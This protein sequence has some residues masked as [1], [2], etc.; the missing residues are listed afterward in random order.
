[1]L[2]FFLRL[3]LSFLGVNFDHTISFFKHV[4]LL[5]DQ[6]FSRLKVSRSVSDSLRGPSK[7]SY[8]LFHKAFLHPVL[9]DASPGCF[10]F[11]ELPSLP[12]WNESSV[13]SSV[14]TSCSFLSLFFYQKLLCL[15][16]K[17]PW[18]I[19]LYDLTREPVFF[20]PLALLQDWLYTK[21]N[22]GFPSSPE[23]TVLPMNF[24]L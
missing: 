7:E 15:S 24:L 14:A 8:F 11:S 21:K 18:F 12:S 5:K 16:N 9:P 23:E 1:M 17:L 13:A 3:N 10:F 19:S 2:N 20:H 22:Q 4:S 6:F